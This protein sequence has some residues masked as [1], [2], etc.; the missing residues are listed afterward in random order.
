MGLFSGFGKSF[1][2]K[3]CRRGRL[4]WD[5][6]V[7]AEDVVPPSDEISSCQLERHARLPTILYR[8]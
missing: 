8:H 2:D 1:L 4:L 7:L 3:W 5:D 6:A